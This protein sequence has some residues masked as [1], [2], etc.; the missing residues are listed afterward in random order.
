[1]N[2]NVVILMIIFLGIIIILQLLNNKTELNLIR[3]KKLEKDVLEI[4]RFNKT[5][6]EF[7]KTNA[8]NINKIK[9]KKY[10]Q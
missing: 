1:M 3:I 8:E 6:M 5:S 10:G 2:K 9:D 7:I 4:E